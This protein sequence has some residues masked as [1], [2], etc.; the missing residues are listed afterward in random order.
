M[1]SNRVGIVVRSRQIYKESLLLASLGESNF[2]DYL[3]KKISKSFQDETKIFAME[4]EDL[5]EV[6]EEIIKLIESYGFKFF[7]GE[8]DYLIRI[9][10]AGRINNIE[11][12]VDLKASCPLVSMD[13]T[14]AM[15]DAH[16]HMKND[17]T[18]C[19]NLP[20]TIAPTIIRLNALIRTDHLMN[21][22][23]IKY[24]KLDNSFSK[25]DNYQS[26]M[27][28]N[29]SY[30]KINFFEG[31]YNWGGKIDMFDEDF[32]SLFLQKNNLSELRNIVYLSSKDDQT[33]DDII[34]YRLIKNMQTA[35]DQPNTF[36]TSYIVADQ[37]A[38]STP[39]GYRKEAE[40]ETKWFVLDDLKFIGGR[41]LA[42]MKILEVGCGHGRL[43]RVLACHFKAVYGT[44]A[45]KERYL[46]ARY[47]CREFGNVNIT[48]ND[49]WS[50]SQYQDG[51]FDFAFAH[52]V[53]VHI[54]SKTIIQ[55]Y[56]KE[57]ARVIKKNG[58]LKFDCYFGDDIFG[59]SYRHFGIGGR[60]KE[61][62]ISKVFASSSL[63]LL[64]IDHVETRQFSRTGPEYSIPIKQVL[65]IGEKA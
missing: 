57:M 63:K 47:R 45:S 21:T 54:N 9:I 23:F 36:N 40:K 16:L 8:S 12:V 10:S 29:P 64:D 3:L 44:D 61:E 53:F 31:Q 49:G 27:L 22:G 59:I 55:N 19:Q 13:I 52:G 24:H 60:F 42:G 17:I 11:H 32:A 33:V 15:I 43:L 62:E 1:K 34:N 35:W 14:H 4:F 48:R 6:S 28:A 41:D 26:F 56:I 25:S 18:V 2:L 58:R 37:S 30:F 51:T 46:E 39:E 38:M 5:Q 7:M 20:N 50:L 65:V